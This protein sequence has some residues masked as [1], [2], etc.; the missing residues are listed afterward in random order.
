MA[1]SSVKTEFDT[2]RSELAQMRDD[3]ASLSKTISDLTALGLAEG[4]NDLKKAGKVAQRKM[5]GALE[6]AEELRQSGVNAIEQQI[7]ERPLGTVAMAFGIGLLIG[8][9]LDRK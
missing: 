6:D 7:S 5:K 2:L 3:L 4:V 9:L 1:E 8:K